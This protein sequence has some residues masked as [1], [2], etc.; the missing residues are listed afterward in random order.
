MIFNEQIKK[1][2]VN[3]LWLSDLLEKFGKQIYNECGAE[4]FNNRFY[5]V[6]FEFYV[7]IS[8]LFF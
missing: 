4:F 3:V 8:L 7:L 5:I 6:E 2:K 1:N